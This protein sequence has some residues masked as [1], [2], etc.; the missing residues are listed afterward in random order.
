MLLDLIFSGSHRHVSLGEW[1][2]MLLILYITSVSGTMATL[3][4]NLLGNG[5]YDHRKTLT[6]KMVQAIDLIL[7]VFC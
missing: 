5:K 4:M 6:H 2:F 1:Q 3:F 7:E